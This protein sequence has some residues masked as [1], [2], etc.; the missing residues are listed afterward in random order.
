MEDRVPR[1]GSGAS[2]ERTGGQAGPH[3]LH[4]CLWDSRVTPGY[5]FSGGGTALQATEKLF[6][7]RPRRED[8]RE[9]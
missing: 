3:S 2:V 7:D 4:P 6:C 9:A 8:R 5:A 1:A